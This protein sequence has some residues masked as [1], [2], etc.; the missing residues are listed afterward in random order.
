[1]GS[2]A[3]ISSE[4][5]AAI[6]P[7]DALLARCAREARLLPAITSNESA[8]V[9]AHWVSQVEAGQ[10]PNPTW[11]HAARALPKG[12]HR[13]LDAVREL[14]VERIP[15]PLAS[16]YVARFD[17][18][19]L[20]FA[21]LEALGDPARLRPLAARRFGTGATEILLDDGPV[22]LHRVASSLLA[23]TAP[24]EEERSVPAEA[25]AT[26][27][28]GAALR[29]GLCG[30]EVRVD[31]RLV[32]GAATGERGIYVA[33]RAFG[34]VEARRLV[35]HEVFG[36]AIAAH[37][38]R[39]QPFRLLEAGSAGSFADQEGLSLCLEEAA[40][41]LDAH[42]TRVL[43]ARVLVT[44]RLHQGASFGETARWLVDAQGFSAVEAVTL[45]ERAHRGGGVARDAA[46]LAGF[47]RVRAALARGEVDV[48]VMRAGRVSLDVARAMPA[49]IRAGLASA[50][51]L[52]PALKIP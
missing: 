19:E 14:C 48:D 15:A 42:R 35:A 24:A 12:L 18:L 27:M 33:D 32:A 31:A 4:V 50:P 22:R 20:D 47:L 26:Q 23:S 38:A 37:N 45:T 52:T 3:S 11:Q 8:Q 46:Y 13:M 36:H 51:A 1:M 16:L 43:A 7:I 39:A 21:I 17:E 40:G 41:A 9:R 2:V 28:R 34:P 6:R 30:F 10:A 25:L 44:D 29:A 5:C 49:L